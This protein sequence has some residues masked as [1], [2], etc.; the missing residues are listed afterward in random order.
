MIDQGGGYIIN[1]AS[2]ASFSNAPY[3][4]AYNV[5]KAAVR[6]LSESLYHE[7]KPHNIGVSA[8]MPTFFQTNI[9]QHARGPKANHIFA[10]KMMERSKTSASEVAMEVLVK[11]GKGKMEI[12]LPQDARTNFFIKKFFPKFF[13]RQLTKMV[14]FQKKIEAS[15]QKQS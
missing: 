14:E 4:S 6:S 13:E 8:V 9:M 2:A 10:K 11:A 5:T 7:L 3:M 15:L 12:V 1:I